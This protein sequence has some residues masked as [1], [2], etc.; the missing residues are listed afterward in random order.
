M[1]LAHGEGKESEYIDFE[2]P[3]TPKRRRYQSHLEAIDVPHTPVSNSLLLAETRTHSLDMFDPSEGQVERQWLVELVKRHRS[4]GSDCLWFYQRAEHEQCR[5]WNGFNEYQRMSQRLKERA[6]VQDHGELINPIDIIDN[7]RECGE[8]MDMK[9]IETLL[10]P[11]AV[12]LI[13]TYSK[14]FN[15]RLLDLISEKS[16]ITGLAVMYQ[17]ASSKQKF[18][19]SDKKKES[20]SMISSCFPGES[21]S[22]SI[23][24]SFFGSSSRYNSVEEKFGSCIDI[25]KGFFTSFNCT[26]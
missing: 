3:T 11:R 24:K 21:L 26:I 6:R 23:I 25:E 8:G 1:P 4:L 9:R 14:I 18:A 2:V 13:I 17:M 16:E 15:N 10:G 5:L 12:E 22:Y 19:E 20:N 7:I